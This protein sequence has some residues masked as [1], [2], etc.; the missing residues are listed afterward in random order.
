MERDILTLFRNRENYDRFCY[1]VTE[2]V[3][4]WEGWN[5]VQGYK[6]YFKDHPDVEEINLLDFR[7]EFK[8]NNL[9]K[10][11]KE[12]LEQYDRIFLE[13]STHVIS[14][15]T[16]ED[17]IA[18]FIE[19]D[20]AHKI[21]EASLNIVSKSE[22]NDI[23]DIEKLLSD[24][25]REITK[26]TKEDTALVTTDIYKLLEATIG[27]TGYNWRI[28]NLN[29]SIGPI[30][31]GNFVVVGARPD[32][33]KTTFLLNEA[34]YIASQLDPDQCILWLNNEEVGEK[35]GRRIIESGSG[36]TT[37][38]L[39]DDPMGGI[40]KFKEMVG[41]LS[42]I[43]V[44]YQSVMSTR[45]VERWCKK[46]KPSVII[47]D[48]LW[49]VTGFE[50]EVANETGRQAQLFAWARSLASQWG[51]VL[52][53]HQL[54]GPAEGEKF[55][56]MSALYG[57]QTGIQGEADAIIIIGRSADPRDGDTRFFSIPKNKM[58]DGK[59]VK[60]GMRNARFALNIKPDIARYE[61]VGTYTIT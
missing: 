14:K 39:R 41:D 1:L 28:H 8:F 49:K 44:I 60:P 54:G 24:Y 3:L 21:H 10:F 48:Q 22:K 26:Y 30:R 18:K 12:K 5:I 15:A 37:A 6:R 47:F 55:P 7:T 4:S 52:V 45:E 35:I 16:T 57:S 9:G 42:K 13:L 38:Q 56:P 17:I 31:R 20:Y 58:G 53:V 50:K 25:N 36:F 29:E 43:K 59:Y 27:G 19:L 51:P 61:D 46:Y 2:G 34:T 23:S 32:S 40:E 11:N 33:G